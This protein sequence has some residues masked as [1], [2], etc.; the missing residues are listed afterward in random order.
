MWTQSSVL[1]ELSLA[2]FTLCYRLLKLYLMKDD[3]S[4]DLYTFFF[5]ILNIYINLFK[6]IIY[7]INIYIICIYNLFLFYL[8]L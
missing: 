8:F 2:F 7:K 6:L 5:E 4:L 3:H 1:D